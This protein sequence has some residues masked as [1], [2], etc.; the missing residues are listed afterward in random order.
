[1]FLPQRFCWIASQLHTAIFPSTEKNPNHCVRVAFIN[2]RAPSE[3][4]ALGRPGALCTLATLQAG[5]IGWEQSVEA[6]GRTRQMPRMDD[7]TW[8][9]SRDCSKGGVHEVTS[10][11]RGV[12]GWSGGEW[13]RAAYLLLEETP[14]EDAR[15]R[16]GTLARI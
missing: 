4:A 15:Q 5:A 7:W 3:F 2:P 1:M 14:G 12:A 6:V 11:S 9:P 10:V 16:P 8:T 13:E